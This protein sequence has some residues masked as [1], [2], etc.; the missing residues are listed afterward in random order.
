MIKD[1]AVGVGL[2]GH[3][4]RIVTTDRS[5]L[6]RGAIP[7]LL[8]SVILFGGLAALATNLDDIV[9]WATPFADDWSDVW[10][11]GARIAAGLVTAVAAVAVSLLVFSGLALAVGGP[12]Y[13]SIAEDVED[14]VLG[15]V[16]EAE[17]IGW[18]RAAWIGLRDTV[19]L[20]LRALV[21]AIVLLALG[22]IPVFGQTVVPVLAIAIGAWLLAVEL[23][24]IPFVRRGHGLRARRATLRKSRAMTLGFA[25]PVYLVC[26]IPLA[27]VVVFPA[28][29][30]AGTLLAH[31]L[32]GRP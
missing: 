12:F 14:K 4:L 8:A 9:A 27:A 22:F 32:L 7:V 13:E 6:K 29:M 25:V 26:L 18:G 31:R 11:K 15:G 20:I 24:A 28:A 17:R 19:L 23:T 16:P 1:F 2:L 30:A 5:M 10:R 3:G 21:W